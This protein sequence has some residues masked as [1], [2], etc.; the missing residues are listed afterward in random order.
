MLG[1]IRNIGT[2]AI[3][4]LAIVGGSSANFMTDH[5]IAHD[6]VKS[7]LAA[8]PTL[9]PVIAEDTDFSLLE[10]I[11]NPRATF[12]EGKLSEWTS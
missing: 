1:A 3:L 12:N 11:Y 10:E 7:Y 9:K 6:R 8:N 4:G 2:V 5:A